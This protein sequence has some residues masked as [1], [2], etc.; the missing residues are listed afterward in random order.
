MKRAR[1]RRN[2]RLRGPRNGKPHRFD[3]AGFPYFGSEEP[4]YAATLTTVVSRAS[5]YFD[6]TRREPRKAVDKLPPPRSPARAYRDPNPVSTV[7]TVRKT[8][9]R[10]SQGEKY[11]M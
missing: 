6:E 11:L 5:A 1:T 2:S 4:R 9:S 8:I 10:S 3:P 7:F